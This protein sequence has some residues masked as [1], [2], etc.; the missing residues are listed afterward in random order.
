MMQTA[1]IARA[2]PVPFVSV[3][4]RAQCVSKWVSYIVF[5]WQYEATSAFYKLHLYTLKEIFR[6]TDI[7]QAKS[8][9][10]INLLAVPEQ[11]YQYTACFAGLT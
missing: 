5:Q 7:H 9:L 11:G 4:N 6:E 3:A 10:S 2:L 1:G 8:S